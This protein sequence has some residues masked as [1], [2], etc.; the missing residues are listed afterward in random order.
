MPVN[1]K[2]TRGPTKSTS[3]NCNDYLVLSR[4]MI[5]NVELSKSYKPIGHTIFPKRI[6][7][8]E[9]LSASNRFNTCWQKDKLTPRLSGLLI[10]SL[11]VPTARPLD[12][13]IMLRLD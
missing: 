3:V 6:F 4:N 11:Y 2:K 10:D 7:W 13:T 12:Q 1:Q 8:E 9:S 5:C